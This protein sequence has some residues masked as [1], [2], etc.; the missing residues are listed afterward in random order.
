MRP[1]HEISFT[2]AAPNICSQK[3]LTL[4]GIIIWTLNGGCMGWFPFNMILNATGKNKTARGCA[5]LCK[6][7][8]WWKTVLKWFILVSLI[9]IQLALTFFFFHSNIG[10]S[11]I[12]LL[13]TG[14]LPLH[15]LRLAV[16]LRTNGNTSQVRQRRKDG[17]LTPSTGIF[18]G[19]KTTLT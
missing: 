14:S 6:H 1:P 15:I 7:I 16:W 18:P 2:E 9:T 4:F 12:E 13:S 5:D 10:L 11:H 17:W 8:T 3:S 19:E